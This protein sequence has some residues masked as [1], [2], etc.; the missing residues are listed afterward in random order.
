MW[1]LVGVI[2]FRLGL[3]IRVVLIRVWGVWVG[4]GVQYRHPSSYTNRHSFTVQ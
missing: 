4:F 1:G 3:G 2:G